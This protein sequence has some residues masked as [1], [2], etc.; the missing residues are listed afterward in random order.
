MTAIALPGWPFILFATAKPSAALIE[1]ELCAAPN[2]SNSLSARLVK[3][4]EA[5]ALPQRADAVA[6]PGQDLV[7]IAL[8]ADVPHQPVVR[9]V[10]HIMDRRGQFHHAK[11]G[12]QMTARHADGG[13]HLL[14]QFIGQLPKLT[15]LQLSQVRGP[16][17]LVEQRGGR[18][19]V[20]IRH[21][22]PAALSRSD[23]KRNA[24]TRRIWRRGPISR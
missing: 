18:T 7:R 16:D 12:T 3:A 10:E 8:M 15:R 11:P 24:I 1:V 22:L 2:G 6:P 5:A 21:R 4:A 17:D 23:P 20:H 13:N 9:R 14:P 19:I